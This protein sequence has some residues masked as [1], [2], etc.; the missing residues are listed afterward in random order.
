MRE[1]RKD[2]RN[3]EDQMTDTNPTSKIQPIQNPSIPIIAMTAHAMAGDEEMSLKAGMNDHVTK[4]IDPDQ[5]FAALSKWILSAQDRGHPRQPRSEISQE[6]VQDT[7]AAS[8]GPVPTAPSEDSFPQALPGFDLAAGLQRLQG[9]R[10]LYKKLLLDFT[11]NYDR[12]AGDIRKRT[13][14]GR[15]GSGSQ[16]GS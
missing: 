16:F 10:R 8:T 4:P 3:I 15:Y 7:M 2:Q 5:L 9:N 13:G 6:D 14:C 11:S 1:V 12:V